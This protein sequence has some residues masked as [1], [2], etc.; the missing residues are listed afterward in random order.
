M[1]MPAAALA[2][3]AT[4]GDVAAQEDLGLPAGDGIVVSG[5]IGVVSD[6][7]GGGFTSTS[8]GPALQGDLRLSWH[9]FY[10]G[11][12]ASTLN[13]DSPAGIN[14]KKLDPKAETNL[15]VGYEKR[16]GRVEIE[17]AVFYVSYQGHDR[18]VYHLITLG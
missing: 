9:S 14:G 7:I 10:A 4:P 1:G 5:G 13:Y 2:G 12:W 11:L 16:I 3:P 18:S 17:G 15:S 8:G 6:Y